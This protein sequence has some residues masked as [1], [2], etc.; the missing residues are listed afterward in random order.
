MSNIFI[1]F[2]ILVHTVIIRFKFVYSVIRKTILNI[3]EKMFIS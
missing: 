3:E 1:I 2:D